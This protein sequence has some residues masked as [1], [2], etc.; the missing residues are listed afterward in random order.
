MFTAF[1]TAL[2]ALSANSTA[3]NVVGNN[4]ANLNTTGF[5]ASTVN[6]FDLMSQQI[7]VASAP[8]EIGMGVAGVQAV[9]QFSQ[10]NIQQTTGAFDAA[11]EGDGFFM[12]RDQNNQTLYTRAGNFTLDSSGHLLSA[13]G[14]AVQ[15]Y[16]A[17]NGVVTPSGAVSDIKLP[18]NALNAATASTK[19]SVAVNLNAGALADSTSVYSTPV[20]VVDSQGG[21]HTLTITFTKTD[22]N[23]WS[24]AVTIPDADLKT[25][26]AAPLAKG[27]LTFDG[28]GQLTSPAATDAPVDVKIAGLVS[29]ASDMTVKWNLFNDTTGLLTQFKQASSVSATSQDGAASGQITKVGMSEGGLIIAQY[30][31]GKQAVV[32]Q[33]ALASIQNPSS[34]TS[35]GNNN[36]IATPATSA[37]AVGAAG[38]GGRGDIRASSLEGSTVDIATEFTNLITLQRSYQA[39]SKVITTSDQ[40]LQ[41]LLGLIR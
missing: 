26:S 22:A 14:E 18:I 2:S 33:V 31:S 5:K 9:R 7:G 40:V 23:K 35:V 10:G 8:S 30:S 34:M 13:T 39:A 41:D 29:G 25:A 15:G 12:V 17:V 38:S 3:I 6:F 24:Y 21:T 19:M 20:Q 36:L 37:A 1:S 16:N 11:I 28:N 27:T 32:A 4:L